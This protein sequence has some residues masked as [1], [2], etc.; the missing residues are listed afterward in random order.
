[1]F[2]KMI[3]HIADRILFWG[4]VLQYQY[5]YLKMRMHKGL[6]LKKEE[7]SRTDLFPRIDDKTISR[8]IEYSA[9]KQIRFFTESKN[10]FL[11]ILYNRKEQMPHMS[12]CGI[13]GIDLYDDTDNSFIDNIHPVYLYQSFVGKKVSLSQYSNEYSL[14]LPLYSSCLGIQVISMD[15]K[16]IIRCMDYDESIAFYGSSITQGCAASRPGTTYANIVSRILKM[17]VVNYGISESAKGQLSIIREMARRHCNIY[18]V[19]YDHNSEI[20]ELMDKHMKLY[21]NLRFYNETSL[22]ILMT[23]Y[24]AGLSLSYEEYK[25][26]RSII[27]NTFIYA[28]ENNDKSILFID[29]S[30]KLKKSMFSFVD[31]RHPNDYGMNQ[32][33]EIILY[34]INEYRKKS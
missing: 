31:D 9:G 16:S 3:S 22:I 27:K 14:Y 21:K 17:N 5:C 20:D 26:R 4:G 34:E 8:Q 12:L 28:Q 11:C 15:N 33:A 10:V 25:K 1:M 32:I 23:R 7:L 19:E 6:R 13:A 2:R 24:S 30:E 18:V 29:G